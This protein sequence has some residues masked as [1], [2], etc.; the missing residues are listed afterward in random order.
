MRA[1]T[2]WFLTLPALFVAETTGHTLMARTLDPANERHG[3]TSHVLEAYAPQLVAV[4][5]LLAGAILGRRALASFRAEGP[6]PLP[7]WR[8]AAIPALGFLAQ[9]HLER[10]LQDDQVGWLT[11]LEPAVLIGLGLQLPCGLLA[12]WLV[13]TLL[14]AAEQLGW[15]LARLS[16]D[17]ARGPVLLGVGEFTASPLRLSV[18]ASR[19]AGRAPPTAV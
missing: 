7:G 3:L 16:A 9:E 5:L 8:L 1:R 15:M 4:T 6:Q 19:H 12:I 13:R 11:T 17:G 10:V 2:F 14:R 18:L